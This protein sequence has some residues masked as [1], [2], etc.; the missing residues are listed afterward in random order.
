M[1][2]ASAVTMMCG[3]PLAM[4][5]RIFAKVSDMVTL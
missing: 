2:D 1:P 5:S 3:F 4:N